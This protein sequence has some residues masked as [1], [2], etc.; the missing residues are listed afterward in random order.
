MLEYM[1]AGAASYGSSP[2]SRLSRWPSSWRGFSSFT[3]SR[4]APGRLETGLAPLAA[5]GFRVGERPIPADAET[6][7]PTLT[8]I[9][10]EGLPDRVRQEQSGRCSE[11]LRQE[12]SIYR[13]QEEH[14]E[15]ARC[16]SE[17]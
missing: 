13:A 12:L 6:F 9:C 7:V 16:I 5:M 3:R 11:I 4:T 15:A 8:D 2:C 17:G 1:R 14:E 10:C